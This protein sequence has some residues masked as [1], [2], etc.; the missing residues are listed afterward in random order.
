MTLHL[1]EVEDGRIGVEDLKGKKGKNKTIK[2]P[3]ARPDY[4]FWAGG[5]ISYPAF[6]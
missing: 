2:Q 4:L 3:V 1:E 6:L 5:R